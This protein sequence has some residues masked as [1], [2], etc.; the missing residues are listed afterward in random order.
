MVAV[1]AR[2]GNEQAAAHHFTALYD[3]YSPS[4]LRFGLRLM[5]PSDFDR[6]LGWSEDGGLLAAPLRELLDEVRDDIRPLAFATV[7][8]S[9]VEREI[10]THLRAGRTNKEI[11]ELRFVSLSTVRTQ[12]HQLLRKFD[13]ENRIQLVAAVEKLGIL[14]N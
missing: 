14:E 7:R 10:L 6:V 1:Y 4:L 2:M 8:I 12:V 5:P 11:A 9:K 13:V 3:R